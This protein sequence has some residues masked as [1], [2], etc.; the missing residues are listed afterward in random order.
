MEDDIKQLVYEM[1]TS[2]TGYFIGYPLGVT[3]NDFDYHL[4]NENKMLYDFEREPEVI[5]E[6]GYYSD[7][8]DGYECD[9]EINTFHFLTQPRVELDDRCYSFNSLQVPDGYCVWLKDEWDIS[10]LHINQFT[11]LEKNGFELEN[12]GTYS[13]F[14]LSQMITVWTYKKDGK[15]YQVISIHQS[16]VIKNTGTHITWMWKLKMF[17]WSDQLYSFVDVCGT[18]DWRAVT[19]RYDW[20]TLVYDHGGNYK[21]N[22][23]YE[24]VLV[25]E[26]NRVSKND[27][28]FVQE[29]T[30]YDLRLDRS[31]SLECALRKKHWIS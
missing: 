19:N 17:V 16:C 27:S 11:W 29:N 10:P 30:K 28:V 9:Y 12:T 13:D 4:L 2:S 31:V 3:D 23:D 8:A 20:R 25:D 26:K 14:P 21:V 7:G 6:L 22:S 1:M 18:V 24:V 15:R 5:L